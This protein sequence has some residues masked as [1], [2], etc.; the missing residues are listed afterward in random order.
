MKIFGMQS[1][2]FFPI[3]MKLYLTVSATQ[4]LQM[5]KVSQTGDVRMIFFDTPTKLGN[6]DVF[7]AFPNLECIATGPLHII[8]KSERAYGKNASELTVLLRRCL[9]KLS[10]MG[11][12]SSSYFRDWVAV[13]Q[14]P[15][16]LDLRF[17]CVSWQI[18]TQRYEICGM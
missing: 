2:S 7:A 14:I 3:L 8:L 4:G 10:L 16:I 15:S 9:N 17:F 13:A 18:A 5:D 6:P 11:N 12:E 1:D